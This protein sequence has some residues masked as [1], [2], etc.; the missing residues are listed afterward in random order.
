MSAWLLQVMLLENNDVGLL[1]LK[2]FCSLLLYILFNG[3]SA[4][5]KLCTVFD[6]D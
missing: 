1:K 4:K 5:K 6:I 2:T 3:Q